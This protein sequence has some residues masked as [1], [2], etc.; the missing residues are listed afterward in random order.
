MNLS[1]IYENK[2]ISFKVSYRKRKTIEIQVH[3]PDRVAVLA[4]K[5]ISKEMLIQIMEKKAKWIRN[6]LS[7]FEGVDLDSLQKQFVEG[8]SFL[9]LGKDY[10]I[11][12]IDGQRFK[13]PSAK[14]IN[15]TI[16]IETNTRDKEGLKRAMEEWYKR[17]AVD[18]INE[19]IIQNQPLFEKKPT[20]ITIKNQKKRWGSCTGK[21]GLL[22]NWRLIMAPENV[23]NYV[24]VHE[25]CH[26]VEKN[27][28][29]SF[30]SLVASIV[31]NYQ[32]QKLW[33][34]N[35]GIYLNTF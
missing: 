3:P 2:E 4:P 20:G 17:M 30:W 22:F 34:K 19:L 7:Q 26:M 9:Y 28:G 27:H 1:I 11:Y 16:Q 21:D 31:P 24:V 10:P 13:R 15:S 18:K 25:M 6:K 5:G 33:L 32:E 12:I 8:E 35:N 14:L 23:I 29:P